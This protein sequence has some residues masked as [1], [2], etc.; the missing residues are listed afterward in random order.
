MSDA[1]EAF[2]AVP[3]TWQ[4]LRQHQL[5]SFVASSK[6]LTSEP[7]ALGRR[8]QHQ[9]SICAVLQL[10]DGGCPVLPHLSSPHPDV[11]H[12]GP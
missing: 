2:K 6:R 8:A 1:C 11:L 4:G 9:E 12:S 3:G 10:P 5:L 7:S